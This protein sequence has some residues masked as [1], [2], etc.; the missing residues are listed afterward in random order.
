M[1]AHSAGNGR[2]PRLSPKHPG[3]RLAPPHRL[4]LYATPAATTPP[5]PTTA[6]T[7]PV[8][9]NRRTGRSTTTREQTSFVRILTTGTTSLRPPLSTLRNTRYYFRPTPRRLQQAE[10]RL[11]DRLSQLRVPSLPPIERLLQFHFDSF[12]ESTAPSRRLLFLACLE[13]APPVRLL[14]SPG[15]RRL[16]HDRNYVLQFALPLPPV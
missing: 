5:A 6:S 13:A 11:R 7:P 2:S 15:R 1:R 10:Q 14:T 8:A 4:A 12:P 9:S 3:I 16:V